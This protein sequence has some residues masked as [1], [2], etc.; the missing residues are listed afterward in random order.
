M[1]HLTDNIS[2]IL[3]IMISL[4]FMLAVII[5]ESINDE[6][7]FQQYICKNEDLGGHYYLNGKRNTIWW[8]CEK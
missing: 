5:A 8:N 7:R 4:S 1:K 2:I 6:I 3:M